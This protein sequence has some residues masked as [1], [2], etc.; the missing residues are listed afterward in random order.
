MQA[1]PLR[2]EGRGGEAWISIEGGTSRGT[3]WDSSWTERKRDESLSRF[4]RVWTFKRA[5]RRS[6]LLLSALPSCIISRYY[7]FIFRSGFYL[8]LSLFPSFF[9]SRLPGR[10]PGGSRCSTN[11]F[12]RLIPFR[13]GR[14][15]R[16]LLPTH[17]SPYLTPPPLDSAS[18][19]R[20]ATFDFHE[21]EDDGGDDDDAAA[22]RKVPVEESPL[23]L[24]PAGS[25]FVHSTI[26]EV[27]CRP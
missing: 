4:P 20:H 26:V 27:Y 18:P 5:I 8:S 12:H 2:A 7:Y 14:L 22:S 10:A 9:P 15:P 25:V 21:D 19:R 23:L 6:V 16:P 17:P 11:H 1:L 3:L 13:L 24:R